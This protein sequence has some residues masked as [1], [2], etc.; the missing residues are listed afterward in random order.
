[1]SLLIGNF[2]LCLKRACERPKRTHRLHAL[3]ERENGRRKGCMWCDLASLGWNVS[4]ARTLRS[5]CTCSSPDSTSR[6]IRQICG[7]VSTSSMSPLQPR[8]SN[9]ALIMRWVSDS[10]RSR[11]SIRAGSHLC[12]TNRSGSQFKKKKSL[13]L[14]LPGPLGAAPPGGKDRVPLMSTSSSR[15]WVGS[16]P[17]AYSVAFEERRGQAPR[18]L[19]AWSGYADTYAVHVQ[20]AGPPPSVNSSTQVCTTRGRSV[21]TATMAAPSS[22]ARV[23]MV[24]A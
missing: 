11:S 8:S 9:V 22:A 12:L 16:Y 1:M 20:N 18:R 7:T 3:T 24:L 10:F 4:G 19:Y 13:P 15:V 17:N 5:T 2:D 23:Y 21:S 14:D 6:T